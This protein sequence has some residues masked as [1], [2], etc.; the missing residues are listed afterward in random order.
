M[1]IVRIIGVCACV[2]VYALT[3]LEARAQANGGGG[4][5]PPRY[6]VSVVEWTSVLYHGDDINDHGQ[7]SMTGASTEV[8][9][10]NLA[11][12]WD[13]RDGFLTI[14]PEYSQTTGI[15]NRG[16]V[17]VVLMGSP[18]TPWRSALWTEKD[19]L[20]DIG[21]L[22]GPRAF[23]DAVNDRGQ[24]VGWSEDQFGDRYSFL[25]T[26]EQGMRSLGDLPGG[27]VNGSAHHVTDRGLV[28]GHSYALDGQFA[29]RWTEEEGMVSL[30]DLPGGRAESVAFAAND[31][32]QI[33]GTG[34]IDQDYARAVLWTGDGEIRDLGALN[35]GDDSVAADIN[36][37]GEVV[38]WSVKHP[39]GISTDFVPFLWTEQHG[40][41]DLHALLDD[42]SQGWRLAGFNMG[43]INDRGE[44]LLSGMLDGQFARI[45]LTPVNPEPATLLTCVSCALLLLQRRPQAARRVDRLAMMRV[46]GHTMGP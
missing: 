23:A 1:R 11:R 39:G 43:G 2:A 6:Q 10:G 20:T 13:P 18:G 28:V 27:N 33:V 38:G 34:H 32:G 29:F 24:V 22:G 12:R 44:I 7:L 3:G 26:K 41:L 9:F 40:M 36:K 17:T 42:G 46:R 5:K 4:K 21:T 45:V 30:G 31:R 37:H 25:W 8:Q 35:P 16:D 15:N 19:G 14:G